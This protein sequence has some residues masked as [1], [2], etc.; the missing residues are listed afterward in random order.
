MDAFTVEIS[1]NDVLGI[2]LAAQKLVKIESK[3]YVRSNTNGDRNRM[4]LLDKFTGA[5]GEFAV[6]TYLFGYEEGKKDWLQKINQHITRY[7]T[8]LGCGDGNYDI[9]YAGYPIDVKASPLFDNQSISL[10]HLYVSKNSGTFY[11]KIVSNSVYIQTFAQFAGNSH[12]M[13]EDTTFLANPRDWFTGN[14]VIAG[15]VEG[16]ELAK[17]ENKVG[18]HYEAQITDLHQIQT[19]DGVLAYAPPSDTQSKIIAGNRTL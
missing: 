6:N 2:A 3:S 18:L 19:L 8:G 12:T 7:K 10:M 13:K 9:A 16:S 11:E 5:L 1:R 4:N 14:V 17:S 15:W